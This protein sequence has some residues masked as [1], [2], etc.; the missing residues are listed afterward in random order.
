MFVTPSVEAAP[1]G[2]KVPRA[3]VVPSRMKHLAPGDHN[4]DTGNMVERRTFLKASK[5]EIRDGDGDGTIYDGTAEERATNPDAKPEADATDA[6]WP[7]LKGPLEEQAEELIRNNPN[8]DPLRS[9]AKLWV[10]AK[11]IERRNA[12]RAELDQMIAFKDDLDTEMQTM[13]SPTVSDEQRREARAEVQ[14]MHAR[15]SSDKELRKLIQKYS[16]NG[17]IGSAATNAFGIVSTIEDG[18]AGSDTAEGLKV[19]ADLRMEHKQAVKAAVQDGQT[20]PVELTREYWHEGWMTPETKERSISY[21]SLN[22]ARKSNRWQANAREYR[23]VWRASEELV[24]AKL[25]TVTATI[26][27]SREA[28]A[29]TTQ[30]LRD[31]DA[32]AVEAGRAYREALAT[33]EANGEQNTTP[34]KQA[35]YGRLLE[36]KERLDAANAQ[37]KELKK[38]IWASVGPEHPEEKASVQWKGAEGPAYD[39]ASEFL[40]LVMIVDHADHVPFVKPTPNGSTRAAARGNTIY[41]PENPTAIEIIHETGHTIDN[42]DKQ[43]LGLL[44]HGYLVNATSEEELTPLGGGPDEWGAKDGFQREYA[45]RHYNSNKVSEV[46]AVGLEQLYR[47]PVA[48][49][50]EAPEHFS[51]TVAA[52]SGLLREL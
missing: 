45:G 26:E 9:P 12:A 36:M 44:S 51:F 37:Q 43:R 39:E 7:K 18:I 41:M 1:S 6:E 4:A 38:A 32:E 15:L 19:T 11:L 47:D 50:D 25:E 3:F 34:I 33:A 8:P 30:V 31:L 13:L 29:A 16:D 48:F 22:K 46:L 40:N 5:P 42:A 10:A 2:Q 24:A 20:I 23:R 49:Q 28:Y 52:I 17:T 27:Q 14:A 35:H 21:D